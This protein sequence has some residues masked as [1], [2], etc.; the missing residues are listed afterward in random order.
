MLGLDLR[1]CILKHYPVMG[2]S[3]IELSWE[4]HPDHL[5]VPHG[6]RAPI[7]ARLLSP[8]NAILLPDSA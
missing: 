1:N 7:H 6:R 2:S 8:P 3:L 5:P 4:L